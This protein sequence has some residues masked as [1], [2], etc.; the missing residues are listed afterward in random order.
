MELMIKPIVE[1]LYRLYNDKKVSK[2]KIIQMCING[3]INEDEKEYILG[4]E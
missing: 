3:T 2:E 1:S 4:K